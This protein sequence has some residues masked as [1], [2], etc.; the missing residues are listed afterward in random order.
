M[1]LPLWAPNEPTSPNGSIS[2]A[3]SAFN[4]TI[5]DSVG[6]SLAV[7]ASMLFD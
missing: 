7:L 6:G 5:S 2:S 3:G 4:G 1:N